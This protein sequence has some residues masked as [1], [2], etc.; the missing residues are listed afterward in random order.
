MYCQC[1]RKIFFWNNSIFFSS[2]MIIEKLSVQGR[3]LIKKIT[4]ILVKLS[5]TTSITRQNRGPVWD[6]PVPDIWLCF[7]PNFF[8]ILLIIFLAFGEIIFQKFVT[9]PLLGWEFCVVQQ[10]TFCPHHDYKQVK[11][12]KK[13][14][15]FIIGRSPRDWKI[16]TYLQLAQK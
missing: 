10:D 6:K 11:F 3:W 16:T 13:L 7:C 14:R 1:L 5:V 2:R 9:N 8:E 15:L 4:L 12:Y